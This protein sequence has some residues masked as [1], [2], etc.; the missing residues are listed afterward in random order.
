MKIYI[1]ADIEGVAGFAFSVDKLE[2]RQKDL[3]Y[4]KIC[5]LFTLEI[6][7]AVEAAL[8]AGADKI[9]VHDNHGY[10]YN[11]DVELLHPEAEIIHGIATYAPNWLPCLDKT[12]DAVIGIGG[13][14]MMGT[15]GITPHTLFE[16]NGKIRLGEFHMAAALAG[17][18][19]IPFICASGDNCLEKQLKEL[20][21]DMEYACVKKALSPY[22]AH[23]VSPEKSRLL[24]RGKVKTAIGRIE[25]IRPFKIPAKAPFKVGVLGSDLQDPDAAGIDDDFWNA[26]M[27]SLETIFHYEYARMTPWPVMPRGPM[28]NKHQLAKQK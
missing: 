26:V 7:A 15:N 6:N 17:W 24:I 20:V 22:Y 13:H 14:A 2:G 10:G 16:V 11:I 9:L 1:E 18:L 3:Y 8:E 4:E 25:K 28:L 19:G 23:S 21:P 5:R 27:K 12:V